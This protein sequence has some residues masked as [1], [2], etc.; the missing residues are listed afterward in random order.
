MSA[1]SESDFERLLAAHVHRELAGHEADRLRA[2]ARGDAARERE[3]AEIGDLHA[4]L[5]AER[6]LY[7]RA[8]T[9][10]APREEADPVYRR[11]ARRAAAAEQS[12]REAA[13]A[14]R[15]V[16]ARRPAFGARARIAAAAA[17]VLGACALLPF[18]L[19]PTAPPDTRWHVLPRILLE[20]E[21]S[22]ASRTLSWHAVVGA[23]TYD[24]VIVDADDQTVLARP[25]RAVRS[26]LWELT[27]DEYALLAK[28]RKPLYLRVVA[29]DGAGLEVAS[30]G[31]LRLEVK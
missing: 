20:P 29:R 24:V 4:R 2:L 31:D 17:A 6:A 15:A 3:V 30:T 21:I 25:D 10:L 8:R 12:L 1:H 7:R 18:L 16:P 19:R 13:C 5:D 28:S 9:P 22:P 14:P 11:L 27:A 23:R 26:T